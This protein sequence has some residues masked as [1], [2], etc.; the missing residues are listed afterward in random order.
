MYV[1]RK[2]IAR[3]VNIIA[4]AQ[5]NRDPARGAANDPVKEFKDAYCEQLREA[6]DIEQAA[7]VILYC[8]IDNRDEE[9]PY[10]NY[11]VLKNRRGVRN[12]TMSM[13]IDFSREALDWRQQEFATLNEDAPIPTLT[14]LTGM[15]S[16]QIKG[17]QIVDM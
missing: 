5:L 15:A 3:K 9:T 2:L 17:R 11:R 10:M 6:A 7:E 14:K 16:P 4:A 13:Q 1:L 12:V 8:K